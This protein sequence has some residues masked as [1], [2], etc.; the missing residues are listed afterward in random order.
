MK[1]TL[2]I[3]TTIL[4]ALSLFSC[5]EE[6]CFTPPQPIVF[7]FVNADGDNLIASGL[8]T[9]G[10]IVIQQDLGNGSSLRINVQ[11]TE[12][13]KA[14]LENVGWFDGTRNYTVYLIL[15]SV[16]SFNFSIRSSKIKN[17]CSG[18]I[19]DDVTIENTLST[20]QDGYYRVIMN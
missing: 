15:D 10:E 11:I 9:N 13:N 3:F 5:E 19:I 4:L 16:K 6:N 18:Y 12:D 1:K 2:I 20:K 7:E 8:L 14:L 17:N